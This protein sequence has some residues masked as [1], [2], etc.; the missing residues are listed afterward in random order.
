M[1]ITMVGAGYV[2]LV[3]GACFSEFGIDVV[4]VDRDEGR[5]ARLQSGEVPIYEPG[6][7]RLVSRNTEAGRLTFTTELAPSVMESDA[8]FIAV[9]TPGHRGNGKTDLSFV[10]SAAEEVARVIERYSVIVTKSTVPVGTGRRVEEV[11]RRIRPRAEFDVV[12]NPEFLREGSAVRDFLRP[13]R[14]I[15][16]S[17]SE[18]AARLMDEIYGPLFFERTPILHTSRETAELIKYAANSFLATKIAFINEMADYCESV[19]ANVLD[20]A[21]G[22]GLDGRIGDRFL[23]P[24]PGYGGSCFPKDTQALAGGARESGTPLTIVEAVIAANADRKRSMAQRIVSLLGGTRGKTV[25]LLGLSFKPD[26]DD[27]RESPSLAIASELLDRGVGVR[28][29]D[30]VAMEA[31]SETMEGLVTCTGPYEAAAGADAIVIVTEWNEFRSLDLVRLRS[32]LNQPLMIDLRN[33]YSAA[34]I[35]DAG[36]A[37]HGVG[38]GHLDPPS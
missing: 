3:S 7:P 16:G 22:I 27:I 14:I 15:V 4:C 20:V 32:L 37:Y 18:R 23:H 6:L 35:I 19:G 26:T 9:G 13:D 28:A 11:M 10:F 25:A 1:R 5:V 2:G 38:L 8:I 36:F 29:F 30:P 34:D 24:G 17:E 12:S 21:R 33:M 31:A